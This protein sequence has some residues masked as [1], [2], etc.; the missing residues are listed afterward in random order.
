[1]NSDIT[2]LLI[3]FI[4][5]IGGEAPKLGLPVWKIKRQLS[6]FGFDIVYDNIHTYNF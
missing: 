1:M 6:H 2:H 4:S 3:L 5:N